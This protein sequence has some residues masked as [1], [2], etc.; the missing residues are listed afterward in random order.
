MWVYGNFFFLNFIIDGLFS[1]LS[2]IVLNTLLHCECHSCLL[3]HKQ[4]Q[5]DVQCRLSSLCH[6][7]QLHKCWYAYDI[8]AST[9]NLAAVTHP[10]RWQSRQ[11]PPLLLL[12]LIFTF[13]FF[14]SLFYT[15]TT[16][17]CVSFL[18]IHG[19]I[20][21][22]GG[23]HPHLFLWNTI[24]WTDGHFWLWIHKEQL[25]LFVVVLAGKKQSHQT[26]SLA[27]E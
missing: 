6:C 21:N 10:W 11:W 26:C 2:K 4:I 19:S 14:F 7:H 9:M 3:K 25:S 22:V 23:R 12:K 13:T 15:G 24:A 5:T 16:L 8:I 27:T 20:M 18:S 17:A 1:L